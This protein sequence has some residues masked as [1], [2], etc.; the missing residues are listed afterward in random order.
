[1]SKKGKIGQ[2]PEDLRELANR[3]IEDGA[4]HRSIINELEKHRHR[5]PDK[6]TDITED[7]VTNWKRWGYRQWV[8][9]RD[10]KEDLEARR[11]FAGRLIDAAE[12]GKLNEAVLQ[13]GVAKLYHLLAGYDQEGLET[14]LIE[15][16]A[17]YARLVN[18]LS[19]LSRSALDIQKYKEHVRQHKERIEA[20]LDKAAIPG[21]LTQEGLAA[22]QKELKLL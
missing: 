2:L 17:L 7:N 3:L 13:I 6:M 1:M 19:R 22:I 16:P 12:D 8:Q 5:W 18:A 15:N 21:G 4:Q 20:E 14:K 9:E 11:D 10:L